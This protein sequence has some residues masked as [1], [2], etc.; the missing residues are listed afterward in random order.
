MLLKS[1]R[2]LVTGPRLVLH[3]PVVPSVPGLPGDV[4]GTGGERSVASEEG[5]S[6]E[7]DVKAGEATL[8]EGDVVS[9]SEE[10]LARD[11]S[12]EFGSTVVVTTGRV[13]P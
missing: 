6:R 10:G 11:T 7:G 8:L 5:D 9:W 2:G 13:K 1:E 3:V 4:A 12:S